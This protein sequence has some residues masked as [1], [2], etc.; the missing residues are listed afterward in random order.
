MQSGEPGSWRRTRNQWGTE[1]PGGK[2]M[3]ILVRDSKQSPRSELEQ[4]GG[5]ASAQASEENP[6]VSKP[7]HFGP[8][9]RPPP[10][11][12]RGGR[13]SV[14]GGNL[15]GSDADV[16]GGA[17]AGG[18]VALGAAVAS[19]STNPSPPPPPPPREA[20]LARARTLS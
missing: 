20:K 4:S 8:S 1:S 9:R 10:P 5:P 12:P 15:A 17:N 11:P 6:F 18:A 16:V 19:Q 3:R 13:V 14:R 2:S 7:E